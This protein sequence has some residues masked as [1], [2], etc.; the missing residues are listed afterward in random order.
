MST[1]RSTFGS[2]EVFVSGYWDDENGVMVTYYCSSTLLKSRDVDVAQA[3]DDIRGISG[4]PYRYCIQRVERKD[5]M[6]AEA[7]H[8]SQMLRQRKPQKR[9][10]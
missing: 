8:R 4:L 7:L 10:T 6:L 5:K 1:T 9:P 3:F 2:G